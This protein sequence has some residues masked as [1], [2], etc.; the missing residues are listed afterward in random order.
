MNILPCHISPRCG[1]S[2]KRNGG[3]P[4]RSPAVKGKNRCRIHGGAKGS[5]AQRGNTNALKDGNTT[6]KAKEFRKTVRQLIKDS[7]TLLDECC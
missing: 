5:G 3:K 2:T 7:G 4:C 6:K 1:A